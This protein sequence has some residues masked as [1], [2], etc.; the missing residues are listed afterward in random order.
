M[1]R[2]VTFD[3]T[4]APPAQGGGLTDHIPPGKY[5][6]RVTNIEDGTAK[7]GKRMLTVSFEVASGDFIGKR[8]VERFVLATDKPG[9]VPFGLKRLHAFLLSLGLPVQQKSTKLDLDKLVGQTCDADVVDDKIEASEQYPE[10]IVSRINTF[11]IPEAATKPAAPKA[12]EPAPAPA[13]PTP[14]P[15]PAPEPAPTPTPTPAAEPAAAP[16]A[17][18]DPPAQ[19]E[20]EAADDLTAI[21]SDIDDLFK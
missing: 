2:I 6:L 5:R 13:A 12:Q 11:H 19:P 16:V 17:V 3:F 21:A 7:S 1:P 20:A 10:R 14:P 15:A 18:A 9:E 4:D 8:L